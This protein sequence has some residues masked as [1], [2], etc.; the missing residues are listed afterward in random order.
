MT[1]TPRSSLHRVAAVAQEPQP[2]SDHEKR[3]LGRRLWLQ[4]GALVVMPGWAPAIIWDACKAI[5]QRL[6]GK[7][8]EK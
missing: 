8:G 5:A 1:T 2:M 4:H 3:E 6:Y 7:R